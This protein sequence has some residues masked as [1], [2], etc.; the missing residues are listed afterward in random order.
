MD[1]LTPFMELSSAAGSPGPAPQPG[2][3]ARRELRFGHRWLYRAGSQRPRP[4]P[5]RRNR[6]DL[7]RNHLG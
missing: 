6:S 5:S 4:Q 2:A 1:V 7:G 3:S